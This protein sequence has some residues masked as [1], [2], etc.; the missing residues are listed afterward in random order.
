MTK[1]IQA[2]CLFF[3][4]SLM[5]VGCDYDCPDCQ[6]DDEDR[7]EWLPEGG[8]RDPGGLPIHAIRVW[9]PRHMF[10]F[11]EIYE[12][13]YMDLCITTN[14]SAIPQVTYVRGD[15][16]TESGRID[17]SFLLELWET[18]ELI[19]VYCKRLFINDQ[20]ALDLARYRATIVGQNW[21]WNQR[22]ME[23]RYVPYEE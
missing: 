22:I 18:E 5:T 4:F 15:L 3:L 20:Y 6:N 23:I 12:R 2:F 1:K 14:S 10:A 9:E 16:I 11:E 19:G 13:N 21:N 17:K 7:P 8:M